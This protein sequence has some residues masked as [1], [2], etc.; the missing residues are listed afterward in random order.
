MTQTT[1]PA[2]RMRNLHRG[3][4]PKVSVPNW[5]DGPSSSFWVLLGYGP[6]NWINCGECDTTFR[7]RIPYI[8]GNAWRECPGCHTWNYVHT[9]WR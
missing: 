6:K 3:T 7:A 9:S 5:V 1:P 8:V 4:V 2:P